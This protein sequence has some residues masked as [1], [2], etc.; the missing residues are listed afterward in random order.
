[1]EAG[2]SGPWA[3]MAFGTFDTDPSLGPKS[4]PLEDHQHVLHAETHIFLRFFDEVVQKLQDSQDDL[5]VH[6]TLDEL[7]NALQARK[8]NATPDDWRAFVGLC[9][10][11][12]VMSLLHQDPFTFRAFSKPRGYAG[13]A[14]MMDF[15][16]GREE[17]WAPPPAEPIGHRV[18]DFT[19][20]APASEGVRARRA[21]IASRI[22]RLAEERSRPH[23]M[24][25]AAGHLREA[26][27]SAAVR[28]R[29]TGR[30]LALDADPLSS[31]EVQRMYGPNGVE[32]VTASFRRLL[33]NHSKTGEFDLVY[34]TGLFDYLS[35][36]TGRRLVYGMF[37]MLRPG[38]SVVVANFLPAVR[39][40]GYMETFM[41]WNLIYRSRA[42]M[43]DLTMDIPEEEVKEVKLVSEDCHNIVFLQ[44]TRN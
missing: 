3:I 19:T 42:D 5:F 31:A 38:G 25:I 15:I 6:Q 41:D 37:Q 40:I 11:H 9:R 36:R 44:L 30:F 26:C 34:S 1:M 29:K 12:P 2:H 16:Y 7:F 4:L 13:D 33:V 23:I 24:S 39:D 20:S 32:T 35:Q 10:Q 27:L 43:V 18:F 21:F 8:L 14:V 22:D 28:R 17:Q